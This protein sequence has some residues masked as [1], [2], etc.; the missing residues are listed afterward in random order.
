[1]KHFVA[2]LTLALVVTAAPAVA[3]MAPPVSVIQPQQ[4]GTMSGGTSNAANPRLDPAK[5]P[6]AKAPP[7]DTVTKPAEPDKPAAGK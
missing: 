7:A 1:M 6:D 3:Q 2:A 5:T 4:T